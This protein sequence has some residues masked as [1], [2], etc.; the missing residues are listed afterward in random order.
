MSA[1]ER[2]SWLLLGGLI[3]ALIVLLLV[4]LVDT[5]QKLDIATQE[6]AVFQQ[7]LVTTEQTLATTNQKLDAEIARATVMS[8]EL[9]VVKEKLVTTEQTLATTEQ[10]LTVTEQ[11]LATS[12]QQLTA[13]EQVLATTQK[14]LANTEQELA[15]AR[16]RLAVLLPTV[17]AVRNEQRKIALT[18][19]DGPVRGWTDR[20]LRVLENNGVVATFFLTG[21]MVEVYPD[22]LSSILR[23]GH[24]VGN[25]SHTHRLLTNLSEEEVSWELSHSNEIL[26]R[27]GGVTPAT[28]R[29]PFGGRNRQ[30]D[31]IAQA[32]GMRTIMWDVDPQDWRNPSAEEMVQ[33]VLSRTRS[34]SIILFHEGRNNTLA[35]LP[36]IIRGLQERGFQFV[37]VSYLLQ[38]QGK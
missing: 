1:T 25:H 2:R 38:Q 9:V 14:K 36:P 7:R 24:E 30:I 19:D 26:F 6:I 27:H 8:Q 4:L 13:T 5:E 21:R 16:R 18:F 34:G 37:T 3:A 17:S 23:A 32:Q 15:D 33:D 20:Y 35:A 10:A 29:P 22:G 11:A 31:A 28:F 12:E